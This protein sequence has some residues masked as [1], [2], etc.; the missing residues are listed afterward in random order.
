MVKNTS[1]LKFLIVLGIDF[2]F[3][4]RINAYLILEKDYRERERERERERIDKR[5]KKYFLYK[6]YVI[7]QKILRYR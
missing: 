3:Q 1:T 6:N 4:T 7:K 2:T 5:E